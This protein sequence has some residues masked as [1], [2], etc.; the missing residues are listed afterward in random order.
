M[1][2]KVQIL[3]R[4]YTSTRY[5]VLV[6]IGISNHLIF[7]SFRVS[8]RY[9]TKS[10]FRR[11]PCYYLSRIYCQNVSFRNAKTLNMIASY[12][13]L[14]EKGAVHQ[15]VLTFVVMLLLLLKTW[16]RYFDHDYQQIITRYDCCC[17]YYYY[18]IQQNSVPTCC[19]CR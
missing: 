11:F 16:K 14:S 15:M 1:Y 12:F 9:P 5:Q 8:F 17:Y 13:L 6:I 18:W 7:L 4:Y 10:Q 3:A 2:F 19:H